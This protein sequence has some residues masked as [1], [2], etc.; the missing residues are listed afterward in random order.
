M[1]EVTCLN[2]TTNQTFTKYFD[3]IVEQ[4][5]FVIK[6]KYSKKIRVIGISCQTQSEY[7]Y[8]KYSR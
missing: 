2:L 1:N 5:K 6:C 3:S 7:K 8:V 4:R